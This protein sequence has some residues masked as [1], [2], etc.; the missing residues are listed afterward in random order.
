LRFLALCFGCL[1][2]CTP[3]PTT[4]KGGPGPG[5]RVTDRSGG[6]APHG[7]VRVTYYA[8]A[9]E[10]DTRA[11]ISVAF[12]RAMVALG[13]EV[14]TNALLVE[15]HVPGRVR[16]VGS[17]TLLLEPAAPLPSAT[18]F[19]VRV[20]AGMVALDGQSLPDELSFSFV[21]PAPAVVRS[22]PH[23]GAERELP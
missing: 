9:G 17:Q 10:A 1:L 18:R 19:R 13:A 22:E 3:A 7:L 15:P 14:E 23:D 20:P 6:A 11:Q 21:T 5:L 12:D 2:C 16:W 8:P 4:P